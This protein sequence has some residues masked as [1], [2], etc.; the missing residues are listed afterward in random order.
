MLI[1]PLPKTPS[2]LLLNS[3]VWNKSRFIR[4]Q[5][6][7]QSSSLNEPYIDSLINAYCFRHLKK[8]CNVNYLH[9][10]LIALK[11]PSYRTLAVKKPST[12][13]NKILRDYSDYLF[14]PQKLKQLPING[15]TR[16]LAVYLA[17]HS[18]FSQH[19]WLASYDDIT[20]LPPNEW[21]AL[22]CATFIYQ[23]CINRSSAEQERQFFYQGLYSAYFNMQ[24]ATSL[25]LH[26]L[27]NFLTPLMHSVSYIYINKETSYLSNLPNEPL[28]LTE[29]DDIH[30]KLS[31]WIAKDW[32]LSDAISHTLKECFLNNAHLIEKDIMQKSEY[33]YL[34]IHL[35]QQKIL[36]HRQTQSFL[37][38]MNL[39][40]YGFM[41]TIHLVH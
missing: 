15:E 20:Q 41:D 3:E 37:D 18:P 26:P 36:N 35:Y 13:F 5:T 17:N 40:P 9:P 24:M 21:M 32:G 10:A 7:L 6:Q 22:L 39:L 25:T 23:S 29:I 1:I 38:S 34:A 16:Q 28:L 33:A 14:H 4:T 8:R 19:N 27:Y 30:H 2:T 31:Y 11:T 12:L